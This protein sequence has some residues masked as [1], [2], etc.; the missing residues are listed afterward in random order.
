MSPPQPLLDS[1]FLETQ[2][3]EPESSG[4]TQP[5]SSMGF[6]CS[7]MSVCA[8]THVLACIPEPEDVL[9]LGTCEPPNLGAE[10]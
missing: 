2:R 3:S 10:N 4:A 8:H 7:F 1:L 5:K 6:V 9:N